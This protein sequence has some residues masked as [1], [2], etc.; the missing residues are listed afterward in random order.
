MRVHHLNCGSMHPVGHR[1]LLGTD[2]SGPAM[3]C[4]CLLLELDDGLVL[5]DT[6][7]GLQD[8]AQRTVRLSRAFLEASRP[9]LA[10]VETAVHQVEALGFARED[11]RH[12]VLTHLDP[13]HAGGLSDFPEAHVHVLAAEHFGAT[14]RARAVEKSRYRPAQWQHGPRWEF[15]AATGEPWRGFDAVRDLRGLP[16]EV[17]MIPLSGHTR[18]HA[19]IAVS[20]PDGWLL[21]CGDAY[22]H[23][24]EVHGAGAC[25]AAL[26]LFQRILAFDHPQVLANQGRLR[27]LTAGHPGDLHVFCSHDPGELR[28][29]QARSTT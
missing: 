21:H 9:T 6:G 15:Y 1:L 22:F 29:A 13:D 28:R 18:G 5:V 27:E 12:I 14:T 17:L 2:A 20:T 4:H 25:P 24:G 8:I 23:E 7:F 26:K 11:V 16:P 10:P 3:V 19:G